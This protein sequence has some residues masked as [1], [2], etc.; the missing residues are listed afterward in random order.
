[1]PS[2]I[3]PETAAVEAAQREVEALVRRACGGL[4]V[5]LVSALEEFRQAAQR[6]GYAERDALSRRDPY[7]S[8]TLRWELEA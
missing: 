7:G 1:M 8:S 4:P 6:A 5:G 3:S 2:F